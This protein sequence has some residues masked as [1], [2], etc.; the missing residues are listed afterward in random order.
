MTLNALSG[1]LLLS[2]CRG[3]GNNTGARIYVVFKRSGMRDTQKKDV[4]QAIQRSRLARPIRPPPR[5][6]AYSPPCD[7]AIH[8]PK[9]RSK[10]C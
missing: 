10:S 2:N 1:E 8:Q 5:A 6:S 4:I 3:R 7:V 9:M